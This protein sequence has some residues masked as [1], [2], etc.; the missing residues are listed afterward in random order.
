MADPTQSSTPA[1]SALSAA[2]LQTFNEYLLQISRAGMPVEHGL[3]ILSRELRSSKLK[4]AIDALVSDLQKGVPIAQAVAAH[5]QAFPPLYG[6]LI[7][8]GIRTSNLP[9]VLARFGRHMETMAALRDSLWRAIAYPAVVFVALLILLTFL[10]YGL[11]PH[12]YAMIGGTNIVNVNWFTGHRMTYTPQ[13]P[14]L[15]TVVLYAGQVA[16]FALAILLIAGIAAW[17][18]SAALRASGRDRVWIDRLVLKLPVVGRAVRDS[19]VASW[20]DVLA[21]GTE[22]GL[23]LPHALKLAANAVALPSLDHDSTAIVSQLERG[24]STADASL[25]RVPV[26]IAMAIDLAQATGRLPTTLIALAAQFQQQAERQIRLIPGRVM[27][28]LLI[29]IGLIAGAI[30]YSL[31]VPLTRLL[32]GLTGGT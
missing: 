19:Y 27:P 18:A 12:Y 30:M 31:W 11:L 21:I 3:T 22:S 24:Q 7:D 32:Q 9:A 1:A 8:V 20:L 29:A 5:R 23:D 15:A 28:V 17:I 16:P 2:D 6:Q 10:G 26:M 25:R 13:I 4:S 14:L